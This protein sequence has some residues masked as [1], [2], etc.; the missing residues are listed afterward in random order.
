MFDRAPKKAV[1]G[2]HE[3]KWLSNDYLT[4]SCGIGPTAQSTGSNFVTIN[5]RWERAA[6]FSHMQVDD[7]EHTAW[8]NQT[9][10]LLPDS[11][12]PA[13]RVWVAFL[14]RGAHLSVELRELVFERIQEYVRT[15]R[16]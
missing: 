3:R 4:S 7:G 2:D 12:F 8:G 5:P 16:A 6:G 13:D 9:P 1:L 11:S 15:R 10:I 14:R